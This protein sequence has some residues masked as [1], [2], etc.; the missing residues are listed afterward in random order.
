MPWP[1]FIVEPKKEPVCIQA[2]CERTKPK[3][4]VMTCWNQK[5]VLFQ[6]WWIPMGPYPR[7]SMMHLAHLQVPDVSNYV[8]LKP[9]L[10]CIWEFLLQDS[11]NAICR[12]FF[13]PRSIQII[14]NG[15]RLETQQR[16]TQYRTR[17]AARGFLPI[18]TAHS[19]NNPEM[20][21][22]VVLWVASTEENSRPNSA[23]FSSNSFACCSKYKRPWE[24][25]RNMDIGKENAGKSTGGRQTMHPW[26]FYQFNSI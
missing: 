7:C 14:L 17:N 16:S 4:E 26:S 21:K 15:L 3:R 23:V 9:F 6:K 2:H 1:S 10:F 8:L 19:N 11:Q 18:L 12:Y 5:W 24:I 20:I 22:P 25:D 13:F